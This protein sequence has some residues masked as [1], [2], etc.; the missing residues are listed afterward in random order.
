MRNTDDYQFSFSGIKTSVRY[1]V[2]KARRAGLLV[3]NGQADVKPTNPD[4]ITIEDIAASFQAAVVDVLVYKSIRAAKATG[5]KAITLT[6]GV[7]A[8]SQLRASLKVAATEI[9]AEVYYPP[10]RLCTDNGAMIA[11]IA[12]QKYQQGL[13]DALSL[14]AT[15]NGS[16]V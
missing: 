12:Y 15:P 1:F 6:G 5:A 8:N 7:A 2:E 3:E 14:N 9:G 11:G 16:L 4:M 10:M 13:R